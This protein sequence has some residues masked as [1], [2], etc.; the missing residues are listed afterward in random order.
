MTRR[1]AVRFKLFVSETIDPSRLTRAELEA[2]AVRLLGEVAELK[3]VV[4]R[5]RDEIARL[6]GASRRRK[7]KPSGMEKATTSRPLARGKGGRRGASRV[8]VAVE[9][10]VLTLA[11]PTGS[12]FK[13]YE[14]YLV[15]DLLLRARAV[16]YRR[17]RWLTLAGRT[18]VAPLPAGVCGHFGPELPRFALLQHLIRS[19][20]LG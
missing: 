18:V 16:R 3:R 12:R 15:Q 19:R 14:T 4:G 6:K 17:E 9:E 1:G 5:Q 2:L 20:W 13:G 10:Q 7:L 11:P 8:R